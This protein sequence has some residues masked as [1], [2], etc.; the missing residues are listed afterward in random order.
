MADIRSMLRT[1][2]TARRIQ[3][4]R[5]VYSAT[6]Q[7]SC[8][9][10]RNHLKS[11]SQW[12]SHI[13]SE[14]HLASLRKVKLSQGSNSNVST[15]SKK[16]K[17]SDDP[18]PSA[19]RIRSESAPK[20]TSPSTTPTSSHVTIEGALSHAQHEPSALDLQHPDVATQPRSTSVKVNPEE[21]AIDDAEWA[22]FEDDMQ[23]IEDVA[24]NQPSLKAYE[25]AASI[26]AKPL[27]AAELAAR[28][29]EEKSQQKGQRERELED[30]R[31]E[32]Q[33]QLQEEFDQMNQL[34]ERMK[35]LRERKAAL[36]KRVA[37]REETLE[38][39]ETLRVDVPDLVGD[40][41]EESDSE[42]DIDEWGFGSTDR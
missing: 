5:A 10:C 30:E 32:A 19:K 34:D 21:D 11:E 37:A 2:R 1:Q 15:A 23:G 33:D 39:S 26:S 22:A 16:R 42:D 12:E 7:L 9:I 28:D 35:G 24:T 25:A 6:G 41:N 29:R 40:S 4:H 13:R 8:S 14:Q 36:A 38:G 20:E 3:D 17:A 31:E 27:T 18:D